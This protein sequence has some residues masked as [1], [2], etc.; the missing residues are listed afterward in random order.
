MNRDQFL[1]ELEGYLSVMPYNEKEDAMNYYREYTQEIIDDGGDIVGRLGT[2]RQVADEVVGN[3]RMPIVNN[4]VKSYKKHTALFIILAI[5]AAPIIIPLALAFLAVVFALMVAGGAIILAV[6][7]SGIAVVVASIISM[8]FGIA[9]V[10]SHPG[11]GLFMIGSG[12]CAFGIG[13]L[14]SMGGIALVKLVVKAYREHSAKKYIKRQNA[15][16][17][18]NIQNVQN[19][20]L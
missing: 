8:V 10:F 15:K 2:P 20:V 1:Y 16:N 5:F 3:Q 4:V 11:T 17:A 18:Q 9:I 6:M 7:V 19:E 14:L 12:I 13:I